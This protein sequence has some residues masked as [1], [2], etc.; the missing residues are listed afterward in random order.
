MQRLCWGVGGALDVNAEEENCS[1]PPVAT[2]IK[3]PYTIYIRQWRAHRSVTLLTFKSLSFYCC[4][5]SSHH[6]IVKPAGEREGQGGQEKGGGR[7]GTGAGGGAGCGRSLQADSTCQ[8]Q[9][10]LLAEVVWSLFCNRHMC[11][12]FFLSSTCGF[13]SETEH[14]VLRAGCHQQIRR[15]ERRKGQSCHTLMKP[16]VSVKS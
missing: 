2:A 8:Q 5:N 14:C 16:A 10:S 15:W 13:H 12:F 9:P 7:E 6:A 4:F 11:V 1:P 3:G